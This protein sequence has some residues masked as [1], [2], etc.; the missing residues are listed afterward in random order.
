MKCTLGF[1]RKQGFTLIELLVVIAII[2][3]LVSILMPALS[4]ARKLAG[5]TG[6]MMNLKTI[7]LAYAQYEAENNEFDP[8]MHIITTGMG[9]VLDDYAQEASGM[10]DAV[11]TGKN[12]GGR[13]F[14]V[15]LWPYYKNLETFICPSDPAAKTT[16]SDRPGAGNPAYEAYV[17]APRQSYYMN[18]AVVSL[19]WFSLHWTQRQKDVF[20][21]PTKYPYL[22]VEQVSSLHGRSPQGLYRLGENGAG[23]GLPSDAYTNDAYTANWGGLYGSCEGFRSLTPE[24]VSPLPVDV[25]NFPNGATGT[26]E[27]HPRPANGGAWGWDFPDGGSNYLFMDGHAVNRRDMPGMEES[28][29][30]AGA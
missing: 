2:A 22:S 9:N 5:Q 3:L 27:M 23:R 1:R 29:C 10:G 21:N 18:G 25:E 13:N 26:W 30:A 24:H 17:G 20:N 19:G 12:L 28:G 4:K 16:S 14:A 15:A 8:R 7:G 11:W 6:C